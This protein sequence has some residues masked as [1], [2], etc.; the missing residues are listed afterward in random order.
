MKIEKLNE[1]KLKI[2]F[3]YT[4][5][6]ENNISIHSFLAN[7]KQTQEFFLAILNILF[8]LSS[9]SSKSFI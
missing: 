8:F 9:L 1:N 7:S 5:L 4:E 6:E 3:D 2:M